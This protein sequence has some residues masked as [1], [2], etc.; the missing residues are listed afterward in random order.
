M[1]YS[2]LR[3]NSDQRKA[4]LRDLVTDIIINERITTT[5]AK[6]KE[7]R[8]LADKMVTLAKDGSLAARR[9]AAETVRFE[10]VS[11]GQNA[12]QKLFSEL[13]PRYQDRNGGYTRIIKTV[14]RRGD[15]APMAIIE[16][17]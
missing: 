16:F 6:A 13:G 7:L 2:K 11:E 12:L 5:E 10:E 1:A 8:K 3:R 14:P 9:Q 17:V 15:A 4:L